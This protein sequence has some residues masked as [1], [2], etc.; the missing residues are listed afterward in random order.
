LGKKKLKK[1][2]RKLASQ[3]DI[4][5]IIFNQKMVNPEQ[6]KTENYKQKYTIKNMIDYRSEIIKCIEKNELVKIEKLSNEAFENEAENEDLL[7]FVS[8]IIFEKQIWNCT[9]LIHRFVNKFPNSLHGI[10]IYFSDLLSKQRNYD[11]ATTEARIYLR[12]AKENNQLEKPFNN[13]ISNSIGKGFLLLTSAYT[14][15]GARNYSKKV[16]EIG[17]KFVN[18]YWI[19]IYNNE[20]NTLKGELNNKANTEINQKWDAFFDEG[21]FAT[22]LFE[23]CK[24]SKFNDLAKRVDL[25]ESQ[26]RFETDYKVNENEMFKI[27]LENNDTFLLN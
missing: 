1:P 4:L 8:A 25:I 6:Y 18:E 13:I 16:L 7:A 11:A 3:F 22:E 12:I 27:V 23:L 26:F 20:I 5:K 24:T 2:T 10:R 15:I 14:E 21:D 19:N 9:E 17:K